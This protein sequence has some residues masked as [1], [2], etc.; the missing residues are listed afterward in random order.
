MFSG[1]RPSMMQTSPLS[2]LPRMVPDLSGSG[3]IEVAFEQRAKHG[4]LLPGDVFVSRRIKEEDRVVSV[5]SDG[6]G[7]GVKANVLA[8]LT[9]TMSL[10]Y[11]A[12]FHDIRK[13]AETMHEHAPHLQRAKN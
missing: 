10:K 5:V 13:S 3:H 9:A 7:S 2:E 11:A 4:L 8:T 1:E 12:C 6:L